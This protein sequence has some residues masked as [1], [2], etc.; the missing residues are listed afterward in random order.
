[1]IRIVEN[2]DTSYSKTKC[3]TEANL[4]FKKYGFIRRPDL[5]FSDDGNRFRC[6]EYTNSDGSIIASYLKSDGQ[7]YFSFRLD[8]VNDLNYTDY[9][10]FKHYADSDKY[11]GVNESAVDLDDI[12]RIANDL[13]AEIKDFKDNV[14]P[15][16]EEEWKKYYTNY[17]NIAKSYY[18]SAKKVLSDFGVENLL[19]LHEYQIKR[20][21]DYLASLQH[22]ANNSRY[23]SNTREVDKRSALA[24]N[25][26]PSGE[27]YLHEIEEICGIKDE[28]I[29]SESKESDL[30][31]IFDT[32][33]LDYKNIDEL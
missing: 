13:I 7:V 10:K 15:V 22:Y 25:Y 30:K 32:V 19:N 29:K 28:S 2:L 6:Y 21:K 27:F 5:D 26:K 17:N 8:Y 18:E 31:Y 1:M 33:G 23:N 12:K 20:I 9:S 16:D 24:H 14:K 4:N 3:I 11:N